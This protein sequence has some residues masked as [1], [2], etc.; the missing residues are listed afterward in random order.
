MRDAA[1]S[2]HF[3]D[4]AMTVRL[5]WI[6]PRPCWLWLTLRRLR[7]TL[8]RLRLALETRLQH[9]IKHIKRKYMLTLVKKNKKHVQLN[10]RKQSFY[11]SSG[12]VTVPAEELLTVLVLASETSLSS[13]LSARVFLMSDFVLPATLRRRLVGISCFPRFLA[14]S[15][16]YFQAL[17]VGTVNSTAAEGRP[18]K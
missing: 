7:L 5:P 12:Y 15:G 14:N 6:P 1:N 2:L 4:W 8:R 3:H 17:E 10:Q 9:H 16:H 11:F 18:S 13:L